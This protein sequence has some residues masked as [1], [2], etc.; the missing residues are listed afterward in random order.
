[1]RR[2]RIAVGALGLSLLFGM[3]ILGQWL[4]PEISAAT[5]QQEEPAQ[6]DSVSYSEELF[7][8]DTLMVGTPTASANCRYPAANVR[9]DLARDGMSLR[10]S[11]RSDT[12]CR[13]V[14][15]EFD[16]FDASADIQ[17]AL[18]EGRS[19]FLEIAALD[20]SDL[21]ERIEQ[22]DPRN[23]FLSLAS[24]RPFDGE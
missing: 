24:N 15:V 21:L 17:R 18:D 5:V 8:G 2:Y 22:C 9:T 10:M 6:I 19:P 16:Y 20:R 11:F 13:L 1:M 12:S 23:C 7:V 3:M 4:A 14:L